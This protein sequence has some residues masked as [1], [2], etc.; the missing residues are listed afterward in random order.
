MLVRGDHANNAYLM[1]QG[2]YRSARCGRDATTFARPTL[3]LGCSQASHRI[4]Q[5]APASVPTSISMKGETVM[6]G[7][8]R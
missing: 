4:A 7:G 8:D 1:I 5:R 3:L 2:G 6:S